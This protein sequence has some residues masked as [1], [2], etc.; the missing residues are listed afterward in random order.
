[1]QLELWVSLFSNW[2]APRVQEH[3]IVRESGTLVSPPAS[4]PLLFLVIG[5]SIYAAMMRKFN[6]GQHARHK[7]SYLLR[8][9]MA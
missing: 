2:K 9:V 7:G 3:Q 1:M 5:A 8:V 4:M 6:S